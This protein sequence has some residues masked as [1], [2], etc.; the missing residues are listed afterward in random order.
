MESRYQGLI[1]KLEEYINEKAEEEIK[2]MPSDYQSGYYTGLRYAL[3]LI[4]REGD[5]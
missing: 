2:N 5:R 4:I 1:D 3:G